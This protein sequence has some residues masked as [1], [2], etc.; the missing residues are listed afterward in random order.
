MRRVALIVT[1]V[2]AGFSLTA[3]GTQAHAQPYPGKDYPS[4]G[5]PLGPGKQAEMDRTRD[6]Q[7]PARPVHERMSPED[8]RQLRRDIDQHGRELYRGRNR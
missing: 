2:A 7:V 3:A 6:A 8:R 5:R 4:K 1:L